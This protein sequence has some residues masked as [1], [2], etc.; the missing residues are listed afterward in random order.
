M[1]SILPLLSDNKHCNCLVLS[2]EALVWILLRKKKIHL[3][4]LKILW[5]DLLFSKL[6][7]MLFSI[8]CKSKCSQKRESS[9]LSVLNLKICATRVFIL[10]DLNVSFTLF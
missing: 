7:S 10:L 9:E 4:I 8:F 2:H 3:F 5:A 6:L 1:E